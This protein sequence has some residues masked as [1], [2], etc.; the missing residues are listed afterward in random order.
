MSARLGALAPLLCVRC[1]RV[2]WWEDNG[3]TPPRTLV[4]SLGRQRCRPLQTHGWRRHAMTR[5]VSR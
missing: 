2:L 5:E 3:E 4:D 1:R